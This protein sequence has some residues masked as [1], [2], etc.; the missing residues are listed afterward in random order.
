MRSNPFSIH[1]YKV[2]PEKKE[3]VEYTETEKREFTIELASNNYM[4]IVK[5]A[6]PEMPRNAGAVI[7]SVFYGTQCVLFKDNP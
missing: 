4:W 6:G 5:A 2:S 1:I 3:P 7:V